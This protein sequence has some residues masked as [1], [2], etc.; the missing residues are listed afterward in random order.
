M[1]DVL[2]QI[3]FGQLTDPIETQKQREAFCSRIV[4]SKSIIEKLVMRMMREIG[5]EYFGNTKTEHELAYFNG[6]VRFGNEL[7]GMIQMMESEHLNKQVE[8]QEEYKVIG[9]G[10]NL[11]II[12]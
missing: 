4:A 6:M 3:D 5:R 7:M 11:D 10:S 2:T 12:Y 1:K 8:E 9:S